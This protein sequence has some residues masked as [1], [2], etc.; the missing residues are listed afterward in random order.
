MQSFV[1]EL[2]SES[3]MDYRLG[4]RFR[5]G[6]CFCALQVYSL[7]DGVAR[8]NCHWWPSGKRADHGYYFPDASGK[9]LAH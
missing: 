6:E 5:L 4:E 3:I 7:A 8:F 2:D 1:E 9:S